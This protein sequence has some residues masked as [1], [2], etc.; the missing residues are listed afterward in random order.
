MPETPDQI[1][2]RIEERFVKVARSPH[3]GQPFPVGP[4]SAKGLGYDAAEIDALPPSVTESFA[5]VGNP[6]ALGELRAGEVVLDLGCGAGMDSILATRRVG[7]SG[8]VIGVDVTE[9]ML[10]KARRNAS[11]LGV[12]N[13]EFLHA[14]ADALPAADGTVDLVM[15][16]GVFNLCLDKPGVL[17]EVFRVLKPGG[18]LQMADILLDDGVTSEKVEKMGAWSD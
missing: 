6:L 18:R 16:N 5:G 2:A 3:G 14:E 13:V 4:D 17:A 7:A 15:S 9:A 1:R 12:E 8:R 10:G 11:L